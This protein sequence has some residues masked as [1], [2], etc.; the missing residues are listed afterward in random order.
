M[1]CLWEGPASPSTRLESKGR[2]GAAEAPVRLSSELQL[3]GLFGFYYI[4]LQ[5]FN[6]QESAKQ[7]LWCNNSACFVIN[8]PRQS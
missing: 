5:V 2:G 1:K 4:S 3:L 6:Q 7:A 8:I